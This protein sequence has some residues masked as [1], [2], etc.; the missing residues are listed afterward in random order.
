[1]NSKKIKRYAL[2][3]LI[4]T[5]ALTSSTKVRLAGEYLAPA[6][7]CVTNPV[8]ENNDDS[9]PDSLRQAIVAACP[10]SIITFA[11]SVTGTITLESELTIDRNLMAQG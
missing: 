7:S 3:G 10:G 6:V 9:G 8:V 11:G 1:M 5:F 4:L 2:A